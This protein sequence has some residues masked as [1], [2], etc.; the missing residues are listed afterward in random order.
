LLLV[1]L[2]VVVEMGLAAVV[3]LVDFVQ[4]RVLL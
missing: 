2:V 1:V 3:V 4:A